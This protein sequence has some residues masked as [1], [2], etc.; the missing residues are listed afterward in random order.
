VRLLIGTDPVALEARA[1]VEYADALH[2]AQSAREAGRVLW[3]TPTARSR[4][5]VLRRLAVASG[6]VCV[7]PGVMT[8][9]QFAESLLRAAGEPATQISST[10]RRLLLRRIVQELRAD[11]ALPYFAPVSHTAGFLDL[12][13]AFIAE[14]KRDEIWP[15]RFLEVCQAHSPTAERDREIGRI[16][17]QY[18]DVLLAQNWYDAEGRFWLA[19]TALVEGRCRGLPD[20][21]QVAVVGFADFTQP[22]QEILEA[23]AERAERFLL[24][25]PGDPADP[26]SDLFAKPAATARRWRARWPQARVETVPPGETKSPTRTVLQAGLFGNL[27]TQS[28]AACGSDLEI[29]AATGADSEHAAVALR[30][31][32]LVDQGL[33]PTDIVVGVRS[34]GGDGLT[35]TRALQDRGLPAWCDAGPPV[36]ESGLVKFVVA[37]LMAELEDWPF[38]R[39]TAVLNSSYCR[40]PDLP[41][42]IATGQRAVAL[43]LRRRQLSRD[44][45]AILQTLPLPDTT[46]VP[47][48]DPE[49]DDEIL[50]DRD[51]NWPAVYAA[52]G[53]FLRWYSQLTE[54]LRKPRPLQAWLD[55]I[56]ELALRLGAVQRLSTDPLDVD[57]AQ[58]W[59]RLQQTL[60]TAALADE[61]R[62][63]P[64][65]TLNLAEFLDEFRDLVAG[66]RR[67]PPPE[68]PGCLRVLGVE[69]LRHLNVPVLFLVDLTEES[70]SRGSDD[71]CLFTDAERRRLADRGLP[72]R[73][74]Q[75]HQQ[76]ELFL[77]HTLLSRW[78]SR[79]VLT[80]SA[81]NGRGHPAFPSPY[82]SAVRGLFTDDSLPLCHEGQ[83]DPVPSAERML[84]PADQRLA[85]LDAALRKQPGWWRTV[86]EQPATIAMATNVS[87]A[88]EMAVQRFHTPGFTAYEGRLHSE[89]NRRNIAQRFGP[90][91]QFSAT[92]LEAYAACPFRF[93]L[94][95]VLGVG[96]VPDVEEGTDHR[97]R[98]SLVHA[99]LSRL[100]PDLDAGIVGEQLS[101]RFRELVEH[102]LQ[103]AV[104]VSE[105]QRALTRVERELLGQWAE[106]Y[107]RQVNE[108]GV[109]V[110]EVA[111]ERWSIV[112]TEYPFGDVPHAPQEATHPTLT[113]GQGDQQ[114]H[115]RG[116][117]DRIDVGRYQDRPAF[118][119]IDYKTGRPPSFK[120]EDVESGRALQLVLYALAVRRLG[121]APADAVPF[122]LGY[123]C[124]KETGFQTGMSSR[125]K[126]LKPLDATIWQTLE[127]LV[128][129]VVP[130]LATGIRSGEFVVE[131]TH[132][133]CTGMCEF[134]TVCRV[135]QIRPLANKLQKFRSG[136]L[137]VAAPPA[138]DEPALPPVPES[139]AAK[140][141]R[142]PSR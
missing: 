50:L 90:Q 101:A 94:S 63:S 126:G 14:L 18:Q 62:T 34:A 85:A 7:A 35:W 113:V 64:P 137:T 22:Q 83:L 131:N 103:R 96:A 108:Y 102:R 51:R 127:Q 36:A 125:G 49:P 124:L 48:V 80:Y 4:R 107:A 27:R 75:L 95:T 78:Q 52:A 76:D 26:R 5:A 15:E 133:D 10:V 88:V 134:R 3:L 82:L 119:V 38:S 81:I 45:R 65:P 11:D 37:V 109:L 39:L 71:D 117:I 57:D 139:K 67:D 70:F 28:P 2:A 61:Q 140:P 104:T 136:P 122:Q 121:L 100:S 30:I 29:V 44:R 114:V 72:L 43:T 68:P 142:K 24:T 33:S 91:R 23:L 20:W 6:P 111:E 58:L 77:F 12:V 123:W 40:P 110:S 118:T 47:E 69:D 55:V 25:I 112:A 46:A 13:E 59:D 19:R 106:A 87:A 31:K 130:R 1:L 79:L 128:D 89:V 86:W 16:Y 32:S 17:H 84:S 56:A 60:R 42:N 135:N 129:E 97:E 54:P 116:R 141:K 41:G 132:E 66:E 98:G 120:Q 105:L 93:W 138:A 8:F 115:I 9:D 21:R 53:Q 73:H 99:V 92:E 74:R